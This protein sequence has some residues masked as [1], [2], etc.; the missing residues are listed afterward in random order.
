MGDSEPPVEG[1]CDNGPEPTSPI[2]DEVALMSGITEELPSDDLHVAVLLLAYLAALHFISRF[3]VAKLPLSLAALRPTHPR[4]NFLSSMVIAATGAFLQSSRLSDFPTIISALQTCMMLA[5]LLRLC[6]PSIR[7]V[8]LLL[9]WASAQIEDSQ[10]RGLLY[11]ERFV[12]LLVYSIYGL[13]ALRVLGF[14]STFGTLLNVYG[15]GSIAA[16]LVLKSLLQDLFATVV[17]WFDRPFQV[18]DYIDAGKGHLGIVRW[19]GLRST[20]IRLGSKSLGQVVTI[21][22][23]DLVGSRIENFTE[24]NTKMTSQ[25]KDNEGRKATVVRSTSFVVELHISTLSAVL[26]QVP[27]LIKSAVEQRPA[28]I[29]H[30]CHLMRL[31]NKAHV[32][33]VGVKI[34][35]LSCGGYR[36]IMHDVNISILEALEKRG[37]SLAMDRLQI[38]LTP[39]EALGV[40]HK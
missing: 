4:L 14:H 34:Q 2:S 15:V 37:I 8:D 23:S 21:P 13:L 31:S 40:V 5:V 6:N 29:C 32:F 30:R 11:I 38:R 10:Q 25:P 12:K 16:A 24:H 26:R 35:S 27:A 3:F 28:V 33:K 20:K 9:H 22:N 36:D 1:L 39:S 19:I 7:F 18:G 17:I